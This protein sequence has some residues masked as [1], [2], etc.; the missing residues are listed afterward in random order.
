VSATEYAEISALVA[1]HKARLHQLQ[2][3]QAAM[4]SN[5]PVEVLIEM[6]HIAAEIERLSGK[7]VEMTT[8][9]RYLVDQ[10]WQMRWEVEMIE[11]KR[12]VRAMDATFR[13]LLPHMAKLAAFVVTLQQQRPSPQPQPRPRQ[14]RRANG[15]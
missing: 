5:T 13:E 11:L 9:E 10:Q 4:G 3:K 2:I 6:G 15:E 1:A 7:P 14:Q 8:R 12:E